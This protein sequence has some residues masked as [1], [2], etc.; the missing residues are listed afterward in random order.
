MGKSSDERIDRLNRI[1]YARGISSRIEDVDFLDK[2]DYF[3]GYD[4]IHSGEERKETEDANLENLS[5]AYQILEPKWKAQFNY[6]EGEKNQKFADPQLGKETKMISD[7]Y[8]SIT[9][10]DNDNASVNAMNM[11]LANKI[12][13]AMGEARKGLVLQY[14]V[15]KNG[16]FRNPNDKSK[17]Q[18]AA[19]KVKW[20]Y[21]AVRN[22]KTN[23]ARSLKSDLQ[24]L[25]VDLSQLEKLGIKEIVNLEYDAFAIKD[26]EMGIFITKMQE[27]DML[28][29]TGRATEDTDPKMSYG[30]AKDDEGKDVLIVDLPYY[31]Q[32]SVHMQ[33]KDLITALSQTPYTRDFYGTEKVIL[34]EGRTPVVKVDLA[35][36]DNT[37]KGIQKVAR[38]R[39]QEEASNKYTAGNYAHHLVVKNGGGK[40]DLDE[41]EK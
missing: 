31:G 41:L 14:F 33:K 29:D 9:M 19:K 36:S 2:D 18:D 12:A 40:A 4:S 11:F 25:G 7:T 32:F 16:D 17:F 37:P 39:M 5:D 20:Y 26:L 8:S 15:D 38:E 21:E 30:K 24:G 6:V 35:R 22:N 28:H 10:L 3:S 34:T 27:R 23:K 1:R 13:H